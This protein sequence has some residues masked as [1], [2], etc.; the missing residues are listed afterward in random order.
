[1]GERIRFTNPGGTW[2][3]CDMCLCFGWGSVCG[4]GVGERVVGLG[5]GMGGC[6][7]VICVCVL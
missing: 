3:K 7:G 2:G 5:E 6:C 1:M 4:V